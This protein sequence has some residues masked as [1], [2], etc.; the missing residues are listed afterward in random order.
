VFEEV[1]Q[2]LQEALYVF[3]RNGIGEA[4]VAVREG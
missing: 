1:F 2:G 3:R 4:G